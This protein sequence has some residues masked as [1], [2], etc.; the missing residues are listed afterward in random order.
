M[1]TLAT[2]WCDTTQQD[3]ADVRAL[4]TTPDT[5]ASLATSVTYSAATG[6]QNTYLRPEQALSTPSN[7]PVASVG[8]R[9]GWGWEMDAPVDSIL[10][11]YFSAGSADIRLGLSRA[12]TVG[13]ADKVFDVTVVLYRV[14]SAHSLI[15]EIGRVT[16][17]AQLV[18][19]AG[20]VVTALV[21]MGAT[22]FAPGE[23]F[24]FE[25]W[26]HPTA[27]SVS[28]TVVRIQTES[29]SRIQ[30]VPSYN[31]VRSSSADG[32]GE[33]AGSGVAT[34]KDGAKAD[35]GGQVA[36]SGTATRT[37]VQP[38][39]GGGLGIAAGVPTVAGTLEG[40][41]GGFGQIV[42]AASHTGDHGADGGGGISSPGERIGCFNETQSL[43]PDAITALFNLIGSVLDIQDD[44]DVPDGN[45]LLADSI[46]LP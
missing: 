8:T 39:D 26:L 37:A 11:A 22:M 9:K 5:P 17:L 3:G 25:V 31:L 18:T 15:S 14:N 20:P 24:Y 13:H 2:Q 43:P 10:S 30:S 28:P 7:E 12:P 23:R 35:G 46:G 21:P 4:D 19:I 33:P 6:L 34:H 27:A 41:G 32:G 42:G 38:A 44:P 29:G 1:T 45:W 36:G 40:D 16:V